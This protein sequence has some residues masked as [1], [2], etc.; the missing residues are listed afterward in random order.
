MKYGLSTLIIGALLAIPISSQAQNEHVVSEGKSNHNDFNR[1]LEDRKSRLGSRQQDFARKIRRKNKGFSNLIAKKWQEFELKAGARNPYRRRPKPRNIQPLPPPQ[2]P[3]A[4]NLP[5]PQL[6]QNLRHAQ[7]PRL[8]SFPSQRDLVAIKID[9]WGSSAS[10]Q[11]PRALVKAMPQNEQITEEDVRNYWN[12]ASASAIFVISQTR[13]VRAQLAL[14]DW[15]YMLLLHKIARILFPDR[16]SAR[17]MWVWQM[18]R[19]SEIDARLALS[20]DRAFVLLASRQTIFEVPRLP[21]GRTHYYIVRLPDEKALLAGQRVKTYPVDNHRTSLRAA[22]LKMR[23]AP[24]IWQAQNKTR[25]LSFSFGGRRFQLEVPVNQAMLNY[26][27]DFPLSD[28]SVFV[29]APLSPQIAE[30]LKAQLAPIIQELAQ[31]DQTNAVNFLLRLVQTSFRYQNDID[32]I[33]KEDYFFGEETLN[34]AVSDCEDRVALFA[35]L[36]TNLLGIKTVAVFWPGH[37]AAA[38]RLDG[39]KGRGITYRGQR[40]VYADPTFI[41]A[42]I[43]RAVPAFET[44][45]PARVIPIGR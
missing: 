14:N 29:D 28:F 22:D 10:F 3:S 34:A 23:Q 13:E 21:L 20:D 45:K 16:S 17:M 24:L 6:P 2:D 37:L 35:W 30:A 19:M 11:V 5:T 9:L 43:G 32:R 7:P 38:V 27:A 41:N 44:K 26:M 8:P 36:T 25:K 1:R 33:G 15:G 4:K 40:Y 31:E 18:T 39:A 42:N 12:I